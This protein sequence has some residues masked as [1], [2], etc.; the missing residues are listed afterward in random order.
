M[1]DEVETTGEPSHPIELSLSFRPFTEMIAAALFLC[2]SFP[3]HAQTISCYG[4]TV[5]QLN[6]SGA[7]LIS[8]TALQVG[9]VYRFSNVATGVDALVTITGTANGGSLATFDT[10]SGLVDYFQPE[11]N[12]TGNGA[13]DFLFNFVASGSSTPV[14]LN[15][16]ATS[17]DVDGNNSN[18]REYVEFETTHDAYILNSPTEIDVNASGPSS[19]DRRRFES[20]TF[21][22]A[23]GI[24]PSSEENFV[25]T[26]FF[27][28]SSFE[29]RIGTLGTGSGTRLTSMGFN[30]PSLSNPVTTNTAS[31]GLT[32]TKTADDTTEVVEGQTIT[33]TYLVENIGDVT[34][35]DVVVA[36]S[37]GGFGAA[38]TP[39]NE[40]LFS[41][42]G[43]LNDSTDATV[44]GSW[45]LIG[46]GDVVSFTATYV[47]TQDDVDFLR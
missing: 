41:D 42:G 39:T 12:T 38:P 17:I 47:V 11:I 4:R 13:V 44:N 3:S 8:G 21:T 45:D 24:D 34:L 20:R 32:I 30:C 25:T 29:F 31:P 27:N 22:V 19:G 26:Q 36:D 7:V 2:V 1:I 46:P 14:Y 15:F 23:P 40:V 43:N 6:F 9:A 16:A 10:D 35:V 33:Y 5:T 37:H 18:I 28:I